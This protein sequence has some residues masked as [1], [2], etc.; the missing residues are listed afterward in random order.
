MS[1]PYCSVC[2]SHR[3]RDELVENWKGNSECPECGTEMK[4]QQNGG[5]H[6]PSSRRGFR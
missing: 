2:R 5:K 4:V 6:R 1:R 3:D